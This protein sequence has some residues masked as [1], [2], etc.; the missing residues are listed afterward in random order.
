MLEWLGDAD[1]LLTAVTTFGLKR[2]VAMHEREQVIQIPLVVMMQRR[3]KIYFF[4]LLS[5]MIL[6]RY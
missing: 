5:W 3:K 1:T 6:L 2:T 4:L